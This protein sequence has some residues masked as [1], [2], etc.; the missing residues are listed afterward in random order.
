VT[1][2]GDLESDLHFPLTAG[3]LSC[4]VAISGRLEGARPVCSMASPLLLAAVLLL[5][6]EATAGPTIL[7]WLAGIKYVPPPGG[8]QASS[9]R[10]DTCRDCG[11]DLEVRECAVKQLLSL[12]P[13]QVW[14]WHP[15]NNSSHTPAVLPY[16]PTH[17]ARHLP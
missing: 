17:H 4:S 13:G 15:A 11:R 16:P 8:L 5:A 2:T 12:S 1:K 9:E 6:S 10:V 3:G 7:E 14:T